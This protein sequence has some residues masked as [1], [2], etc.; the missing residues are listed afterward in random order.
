[1]FFTADTPLPS[2][3]EVYTWWDR[4]EMLSNIRDHSKVVRDVA[5]LLYDW[6]VKE[7]VELS[8]DA[9]EIGALVH[10]IAKSP[11][12]ISGALHA[13]EGGKIMEELGYPELAFLVA[14]HVIL[15]K[16]QPLDETMVVNY[17]DKRVTHD[18]IVDL[19]SRYNY[20]MERYG[21]GD[22]ERMQRIRLGYARM[23]QVEETIFSRLS[24]ERTPDAVGQILGRH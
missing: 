23:R 14:N 9:V 7:G 2:K 18:E 12:L 4:Y 20:I 21:D 16:G 10:D 15:P 19:E 8:R 3:Q 11:C 17:A 5:L 22:P 6:L 24:A 13:Q 1:M